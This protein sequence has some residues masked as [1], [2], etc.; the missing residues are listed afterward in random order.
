MAQ[1]AGLLSLGVTLT[2]WTILVSY[3]S[4]DFCQLTHLQVDESPP[5]TISPKT[6]QG[7]IGHFIITATYNIFFHPLKSYQGPLL[8]RASRLPF[9]W[10]KFSGTLSTNQML[11]MFDQYGPVV[12]VAPNE[13][14]YADAAA[15]KD[16]AGHNPKGDENGKWDPFYR[17]VPDVPQGIISADRHTHG[18]LRRQL[19][20]GFSDRSMREQEPII[21]AYVDLLMTRLRERC[22]NGEKPLDMA[23]WFNF[24]T[25]DVSPSWHRIAMGTTHR[26]TLPLANEWWGEIENGFPFSSSCTDMLCSPLS[27]QIIGDLTFGES[28]GCLRESNW[29][30]WVKTIFKLNKVGCMMQCAAHWP[31]FT[32][33]LI[34]M[35]P[36]SAMKSHE[37]HD[38]FTHNRVLKRI[39]LGK[40]R[41][42][43]IEGLLMKQEELVS[44]AKATQEVLIQGIKK[45]KHVFFRY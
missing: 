29:H 21:K 45:G 1:F 42:D 43:L 26:F 16:I 32:R 34:S 22:A 4:P 15:W 33:T 23:S 31:W 5:L 20:H 38:A 7:L 10:H 3:H 13:L 28:F 8:W 17:P 37:E 2:L 44:Q 39:R 27:R 19:A 24:T 40:T 14:A 18:V 12:R 30:A 35:I 25:F 11:A 41:H 6:I 36:K 9:V